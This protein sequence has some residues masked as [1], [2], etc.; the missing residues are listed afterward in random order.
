MAASAIWRPVDVVLAH[1]LVGDTVADIL[2]TSPLDAS[3]R[4]LIET[5]V[6]HTRSVAVTQ[7]NNPFSCPNVLMSQYGDTMYILL[8][9]GEVMSLP[10][11]QFPV[12]NP[13]KNVIFTNSQTKAPPNPTV[14]KIAETTPHI[15][16]F[17]HHSVHR[18]GRVGT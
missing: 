16:L 10:E 12:L 13:R 6:P 4:E 17:F 3:S 8:G 18:I 11:I 9:G 1:L 5:F 2:M 15:V 7:H 14:P